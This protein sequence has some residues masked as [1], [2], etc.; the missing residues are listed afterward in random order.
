MVVDGFSTATEMLAALRDNHISAVELLDLHI[1]RIERH[2]GR[3]N[4]VVIRDFERARKVALAADALRARGEDRPL[5]GLPVTIKD[6]LDV[7]GLAT[8]GG[9]IER[10]DAVAE[11][12]APVVARLRAAGA[13][14][15]GKTNVPPNLADWQ[16]GNPIFGRTNNPW[17]LDRTPGG[18]SGGS[19]AA[20]A[21]GLTPLDLGSD[22]GGSIRFPA[23][24]CGV[25]GHRPSFGMV[26][27]S[28]HF[29]GSSHPNETLTLNAVGP[30]ARS[31]DDLEL[32]LNVIAGPDVGL[33]AAWRLELPP[34]RHARLSDFR[35]G[36]AARCR[37]AAGR[38]RD[39]R[40]DRGGRLGASPVRNARRRGAAAGAGRSSRAP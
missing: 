21:A 23:A 15:V 7:T 16:T 5:L 20:L 1:Q 36:G 11:A 39:H 35:G 14:I 27:S 25:F 30:L 37:L 18:S 28:G 2:D 32:A 10:A 38:R 9:L 6:G 24:W 12:D 33:D 19:G 31:A 17:D 29:P 26:P 13:V 4:A 22:K 34:A 3:V 8:T 40:S